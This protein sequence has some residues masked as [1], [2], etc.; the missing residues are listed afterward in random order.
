MTAALYFAFGAYVLLLAV[1]LYIIVFALFM[2]IFR[3]D[4]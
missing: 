3:K 2:A 4:E 1:V